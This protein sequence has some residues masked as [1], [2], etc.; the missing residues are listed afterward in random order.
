MWSFAFSIDA[1]SIDAF[2]IDD[3]GVSNLVEIINTGLIG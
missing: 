2:S 3:L 1:F